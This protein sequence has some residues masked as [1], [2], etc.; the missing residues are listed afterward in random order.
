MIGHDGEGIE[1]KRMEFLYT[2]EAFHCFPRTSGIGEYRLASYR[3]RRRK[4]NLVGLH[5]MAL[6]HTT[7]VVIVMILNRSFST[8]W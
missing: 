2:I 1:E 6:G 7:I 4:K 5:V 3:H 8:D